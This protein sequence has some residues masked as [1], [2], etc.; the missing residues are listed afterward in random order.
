MLSTEDAAASSGFSTRC[1]VERERGGGGAEAEKREDPARA[2]CSC[3]GYLLR[4]ASKGER[5]L[6]YKSVGTFRPNIRDL[7]I[8]M[9][10]PGPIF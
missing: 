7:M 6:L 4:R 5:T 10:F 9:K 8:A 3:G 2:Y 1:A